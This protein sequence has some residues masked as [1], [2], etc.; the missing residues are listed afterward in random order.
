MEISSSGTGLTARQRLPSGKRELGKGRPSWNIQ[1]ASVIYRYFNQPLSIYCGGI[2]NLIRHHDYTPGG[3]RIREALPSIKV[4]AS[5]GTTSWS[6]R[7]KM[8]KSK[9][10]IYYTDTTP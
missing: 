8:S 1:D 5:T 6:M 4:L 2:D 7:E 3:S 9:G 10:N